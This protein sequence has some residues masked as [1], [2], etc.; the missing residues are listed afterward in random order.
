MARLAA[1]CGLRSGTR[2]PRLTWRV[3]LVIAILMLLGWMAILEP[4][5]PDELDL[6]ARRNLTGEVSKQIVGFGE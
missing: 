1:S 6:E 5:I 3:P 4:V 2:G